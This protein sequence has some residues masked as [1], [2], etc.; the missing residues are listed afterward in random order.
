MKRLII[1]VCVS[2]AGALA[3]GGCNSGPAGT[4]SP[5]FNPFGTDPA[6]TTG[7]EPAG[8]GGIDKPPTMGGGTIAQLCATVCAR[9]ESVCPGSGGGTSCASECA[10]SAP[11]GC[12]SLFQSFLA[13]LVSAPLTCSNGQLQLDGCVTEISQLNACTGTGTSTGSGGSL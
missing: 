6:P 3:A 7:N 9:F 2:L 10:S 12:E 8:G 4:A 1:I 5:P 13:C 11:P